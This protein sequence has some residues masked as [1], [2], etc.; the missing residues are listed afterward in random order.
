ME[1]N[2][3]IRSGRVV[4]VV[5]RNCSVASRRRASKVTFERDA[6]R[7]TRDIG[8]S[9]EH[10]NKDTR[11]A[12]YERSTIN[13]DNNSKNIRSKFDIISHLILKR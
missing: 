9:G 7:S 10:Y 12:D 1:L 11:P 3:R 2:R 8:L 5:G 13:N 6:E 4:C